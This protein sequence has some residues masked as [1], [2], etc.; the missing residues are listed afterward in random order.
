MP[1]GPKVERYIEQFFDRRQIG[2]RIIAQ[3]EGNHGTYTVSIE[4]DATETRSACSCYIG[5]HGYC[6]HCMALAKTFLKNP[7]SFQEIVTKT[8]NEVKTLDDLPDY[9]QHITLG[10]LLEQ[11]KEARITQKA[12]AESIG[13]SPRHLSAMKS[14]EQRNRRHAELGAV[15][16]AC[17]WVLGRFGEK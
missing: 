3:V 10:T 11:L 4:V 5:K 6:H 15:K 7:Q 2:T 17:L 16:L 12:F 1:S 8:L 14:S 13:M 9:L